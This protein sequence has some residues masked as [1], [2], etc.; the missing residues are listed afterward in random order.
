LE[1]LRERVRSGADRLPARERAVFAEALEERAQAPVLLRELARAL[2]VV[3]GRLDLPAVPHDARIAEQPRDVARAEAGD[4]LEREVREHLPEPRALPEDGQ[5]RE[6][7]L[8]PLEADLLE[9]PPVLAH[10]EAPLAIVVGDVE[11][12]GPAPR[13]ARAAVGRALEDVHAR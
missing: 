13:A 7:R 9:E 11:Q 3:D 5:P 10:G 2:R 12:V 6:P 8:E 4:A 1:L